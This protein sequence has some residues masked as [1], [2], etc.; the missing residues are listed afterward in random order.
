MVDL[1]ALAA[2]IKQ[3]SPEEREELDRLVEKPLTAEEK[4]KLLREAREE[5]REGLSE[6]EI[7][8]IIWAMNVEYIEPDDSE[9][10]ER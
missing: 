10:A 9:F 5:L 6:D 8:E 4:V 1:E 2:T 7:R 3:L